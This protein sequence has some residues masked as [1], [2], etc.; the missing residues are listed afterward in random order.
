[1]SHEHIYRKVT[2]IGV[3][4]YVYNKGKKERK[5]YLQGNLIQLSLEMG[6]VKLG[7]KPLRTDE[8]GAYYL[9]YR[10]QILQIYVGELVLEGN[11]FGSYVQVISAH[12]LCLYV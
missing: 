2:T 7:T 5:V 12:D 8:V 6:V 1:M 10:R 3:D 4:Y 9:A 11:S